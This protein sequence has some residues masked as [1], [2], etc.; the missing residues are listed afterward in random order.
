[1]EEKLNQQQM[2][3]LVVAFYRDEFALPAIK[4]ETKFA[5]L[6]MSEESVGSDLVPIKKRYARHMGGGWVI[7]QELTFLQY[8]GSKTLR[9]AAT[10]LHDHQQ[11]IEAPGSI[12][13]E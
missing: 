3:D 12:I 10:Q 11:R 5:T 8:G 6:G 4:A 13:N 1:M 2:E 9:D 7:S